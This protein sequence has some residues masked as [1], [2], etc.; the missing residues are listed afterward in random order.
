MEIER[1]I[2]I[3]IC[4]MRE[5]DNIQQVASLLPDYLGF[6]FYSKSPR[7]VGNDF[8][9]PVSLTPSI[10]RVGVFVNESTQF[11]LMKAKSAGFSFVQLHGNESPDQAAALQD[12]GLQVIKVFSVGDDFNFAVT[13]AYEKTS[14]ILNQYDQQ[15]PFFLSGG[16]S[17]E[18]LEGIKD[19]HH[20]NIHAL[21]LN[22]G[23]EIS[24]GVKDPNK[25]QQTLELT[26]HFWRKPTT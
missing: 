1:K 21:D 26:H 19:L 22:S 23:V 7:F 24:P 6:I 4:G 17:P 9:V 14:N 16:L 18:N 11:I 12:S 13:K 25:I 2:K 5:A 15:I 10:H 3:K 8:K 20:M